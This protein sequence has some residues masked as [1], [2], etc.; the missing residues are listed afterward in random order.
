MCVIARGHANAAH[1]SCTPAPAAARGGDPWAW[2]SCSVHCSV[3]RHGIACHDLPLCPHPCS[4]ENALAL[5]TITSSANEHQHQ[6]APAVCHRR[7]C[8]R[9]DAADHSGDAVTAMAYARSYEGLPGGDGHAGWLVSASRG[10]L[11]LW[12]CSAS[13]GRGEA[14]LTARRPR[15]RARMILKSFLQ[16]GWFGNSALTV[17]HSV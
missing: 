9:T 15:W 14:S 11:N 5:H 7:A 8:W 3:C 6:V 4:Q 12:E 2:C 17:A 13:G 10:L 16:P 1:L